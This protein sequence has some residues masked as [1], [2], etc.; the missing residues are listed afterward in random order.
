MTQPL[1][2]TKN[3]STNNNST[4]HESSVLT[5][6]SFNINERNQKILNIIGID[7]GFGLCKTAHCSFASG[8]AVYENEP[9]TNKDVLRLDGKY[10]VCGTGRQGLTK[11]K[12]ENENYFILTLAAIAKEIEVRGLD[13]D[14]EVIIAAGLPLTTFGRQKKPFKKYLL[15][16]APIRFEY[17]KRKYK[18]AIQDVTLFPQGFSAIAYS[19]DIMSKEPS[20]IL[21]DIGSWTVDCMMINNSIP[22]ATSCRSLEHG[23]IR[24]IEE[25]QEEVRRKTGL[26]ITSAQVEQILLGKDCS[27]DDE[28]KQIIIT[29]G[30]N[31]S[32]RL[33]KTL[34]ESGFDTKAVPTIM[35]GG[36]A[37][38]VKH[39]ITKGQK[40]KI[41]NDINANAKGYEI[42]TKESLESVG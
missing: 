27:M 35:M 21:I 20:Q 34:Y 15:Y 42:L 30:K 8:I 18:V 3:Y 5:D 31:F 19:P 11:D 16:M 40:I 17:E 36:G 39:Y 28:V 25:T 22:D 7:H 14:C 2:T 9:F 33:F 38:I 37:H 1:R 4:H 10:Y 6:G 23:I 24:C 41:L 26:S 32:N 13:R 12:T 29:Q